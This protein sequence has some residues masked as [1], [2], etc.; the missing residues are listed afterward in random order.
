MSVSAS[1]VVMGR[2]PRLLATANDFASK[3]M[4]RMTPVESTTLGNGLRVATQ[5]GGPNGFATVAMHSKSG[6]RFDTANQQGV[7]AL[8]QRAMFG[9]TA[10]KTADQIQAEIKSLGGNIK[11]E[12]GR[13]RQS[14]YINCLGKDA[15]KAVALLG[16]V[17]QN[18][19]MDSSALEFGRAGALEN[20]KQAE[21]CSQF[22]LKTRLFH[23]A[24][25][26]TSYDGVSGSGMAFH[27]MGDADH[28]KEDI[29][30][31]NMAEFYNKSFTRMSFVYLAHN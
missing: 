11:F 18:A 28:I 3:F 20:L 10:T 30:I 6:S 14:V 23:Q 13:E 8:V 22:D 9:G 16:D 26:T 21:N 25:E 19:K 7:S 17:A 5:E 15:E 1:T 31:E 24:Y 12:Q 27:P 2:N 29:T 4:N